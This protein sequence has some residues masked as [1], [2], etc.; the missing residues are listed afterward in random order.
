M[1]YILYRNLILYILLIFTSCYTLRSQTLTLTN[2]LNSTR[3]LHLSEIL[4]NGNVLA[5]GGDNGDLFNLIGR[6]SSEIYNTTT[7]SWSMGNSLNQERSYFASVTLNDGYILAI[8]GEAATTSTN[9]SSVELYNPTTGLWTYKSNL[10]RTLNSH[11]AIKLLNGNVLVAAGLP[12]N[13]NS[14]IYNPAL[15]QWSY[16]GSLSYSH[17]SG[18]SMVILNDGKLLLTGGDSSPN[19]AE[20]YN[21]LTG[22]WKLIITPLLQPRKYHSSI[23][24]NDGRVLIIGGNL[25]QTTCEIFDP[26]S[27][28]FSSTG[29]LVEAKSHSEVSKLADGKILVYSLNLNTMPV[30]IYDPIL[31]SWS[32]YFSSSLGAQEY[33]MNTLNNGSILISGGA[34]GSGGAITTTYLFD[35]PENGTCSTISLTSPLSLD[36]NICF[37]QD[38]SIQ[39]FNTQSGWQYQAMIGNQAVG[40]SV[41]GGG[42]ITITIPYEALALG[43]NLV[44]IKVIK[45]SCNTRIL[46]DQ[47][48]IN[49]VITNTDIAQLSQMS[50]ISICNGDSIMLSTSNTSSSYLWSNGEQT[51]QI[52]IKTE[53]DYSVQIRNASGCLSEPSDTISVNVLPIVSSFTHS[54][55]T[56]VCLYDSAFQLSISP[57]EGS[58]S[59]DGIINNMFD[60]SIANI[61]N[62]NIIYEYCNL[63]DTFQVYVDSIPEIPEIFPY[64]EN[65]VN[66][67]I[68]SYSKL[69][70]W[71]PSP[72]NDVCY[73][74]L[75]NGIVEG[76]QCGGAGNIFFLTQDMYNPFTITILGSVMGSC[77]NQTLLFSDSINIISP[78]ISASV[79]AVYDTVCLGTYPVIGIAPSDTTMAYNLIYS[80]YSTQ[81]IQG[82]GDTLYLTSDHYWDYEV[83]STFYVDATN[84][85]CNFNLTNSVNVFHKDYYS[86]FELANTTGVYMVNDTISLDTLYN[87]QSFI[88]NIDGTTYNGNVPAYVS[89]GIPGIKNISIEGNINAGCLDSNYFELQISDTISRAPYNV[90]GVDTLEGEF[91]QYY[92]AQRTHA[93][94]IDNSNNSYVAGTYYKTTW[95]SSYSMFLKKFD[96][97]GNLLWE[98]LQL[99]LSGDNNILSSINGIDVD[100]YGNVY[101][102]GNYCAKK[103]RIDSYTF[104]H[105]SPSNNGFLAKLNSNGQV[106]WVIKSTVN[107]NSRQRGFTDVKIDPLTGKIF[108]SGHRL[109]QIEFT[110]GNIENCSADIVIFE[111]NASGELIQSYCSGGYVWG[112]NGLKASWNP[113]VNSGGTGCVISPKI[114][115]R[116]GEIIV[117]GVYQGIINIGPFTLNETFGYPNKSYA[118]VAILNPLTGWS[119]A[120]TMFQV[121][122]PLG[123]GAPYKTSISPLL[124]TDNQGNYY[125]C[126]ELNNETGF[127]GSEGIYLDQLQFIPFTIL[128]NY[129][130]GSI[131]VKYDSNGNYLWHSKTS[132]FSPTDIEYANDQLLLYGF[133]GNSHNYSSNPIEHEI[134]NV[135]DASSK[136]GGVYSKGYSDLALISFDN[137]G[138]LNWMESIGT[139]SIDVACYMEVKNCGKDLYLSGVVPQ[140][141]VFCINDSLNIDRNQQLIQIKYS[142]VGDCISKCIDCFEIVDGG[143][144]LVNQEISICQGDSILLDGAYQTSSGIYNID[145]LQSVTGCDSIYSTVL[146]VRPNYYLED[147]LSICEGDSLLIGNSFHSIPGIYIDTL[148]SIYG[149]DSV[150]QINLIV[151]PTPIVTLNSFNP[152][153]I[154]SNGI[155]YIPAGS[156]IG[157]YYIGPPGMSVPYLDANIVGIGTY[158][159]VYV[160]TDSNTCSSSD[161]TIFTIISCVGIEQI[162]SNFGIRIYPN[163]NT[164]LFSIEKPLNLNK[165]V[166]VNLLDATSKLIIQK[167]IPISKQKID[168]DI[169]NYSKGIYY[170]KL[171]IDNESFVQQILKN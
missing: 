54:I 93:Y 124:T 141:K 135:Y 64:Y 46:I 116:N 13:N 151:N 123:S 81:P 168:I 4:P 118:F 142:L 66:N 119:N 56:N 167:V 150:F 73:T 50:D 128:N 154:C 166:T 140:G 72:S 138:N 80:P 19:N 23:V 130:R 44:K 21:P 139:D 103:F 122:Q 171:V 99:I 68:C 45:L 104:S 163:P 149:C 106:Q 14:Q 11:N 22:Q 5:F 117:S 86:S 52:S 158:N 63:I 33:A 78:I 76:T 145:T 32:S 159:L 161:T 43:N 1:K 107:D 20:I 47:I 49:T 67:A 70:V 90:C 59:G 18:A 160:Y 34:I 79:F 148:S 61:G 134:L 65:N 157:G 30:E 57:S 87:K 131:V 15:D 77:T 156:H 31:G 69:K 29:N 110:D 40:V 127:M 132:E 112:N 100:A 146:T 28:T 27:E 91:Y 89:F 136:T 109:D 162:T 83:L 38:A 164:G 25:S 88:W 9:L 94:S 35:I 108:A 51:Q 126:V 113:D 3:R 105:N 133:Y 111:I 41:N 16:S 153:T 169:T 98:K 12:I 74:F 101:I 102:A 37:G 75:V 10:L 155:A 8:G 97:Y 2:P 53:G 137:N 17:G 36:T 85:L 42:T 62:N 152:D 120:F 96:A 144:Y 84:G 55:P 6:S 39:V 129:I 26:V 24:L 92:A 7:G 147:T 125:M 71:I 48:N 121:Q 115:F 170:L 60:P 114:N 82:N 143:A 58:W 95:P 165:E